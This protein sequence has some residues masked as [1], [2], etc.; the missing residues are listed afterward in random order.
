MLIACKAACKQCNALQTPSP[1]SEVQLSSGWVMPTVGFG[2]A[3]LGVGTAQ[4]VEY[5]A[6]A[7]YRMFDSAEVG[8]WGQ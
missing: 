8:L 6:A 7:G 2:T 3:G 1:F 5:S 4:A